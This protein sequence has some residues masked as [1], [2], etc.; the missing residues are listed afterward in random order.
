MERFDK[1]APDKVKQIG[2]EIA[3]IG[4]EGLDYGDSEKKYRLNAIPGETFS[5]LQLLC[6]MFV[7][8]KRIDP[9][10][11]QHLN[12]EAPYQMAMKMHGGKP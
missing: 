7:A 10:L 3:V 6:M 5:G 11:D 4:M 2:L 8:F 1:L 12:L 9:T